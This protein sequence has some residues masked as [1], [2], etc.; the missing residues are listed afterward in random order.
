MRKI[1]YREAVIEA[2]R[3]EMKRD[4][5]VYLLGED[6]AE[7]GGSYKTTLAVCWRDPQCHRALVI[8]HGGDWD[9]INRPFLSRPAFDQAVADG[10]DG[11][12]ADVRVTL[13]QVPVIAHSLA[14]QFPIVKND[15]LSILKS[16]D[17]TSIS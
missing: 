8:A 17:Q 6:I 10:A 12:E 11:I 1:T 16:A 15:L 2:L 13:D 9:T 14:I 3:E 4:P 5:S 7:F